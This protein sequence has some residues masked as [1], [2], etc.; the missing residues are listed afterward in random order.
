VHGPEIGVVA[1]A[2]LFTLACAQSAPEPTVP[3]QLFS[4]VTA[5]QTRCATD[6][7]C[8]VICLDDGMCCPTYCQA[9][10]VA[11]RTDAVHA[12]RA[13]HER[14]CATVDVACPSPGNCAE[15]DFHYVGI[16]SDGVCGT[17]K[18]PGVRSSLGIATPAA[19]P[20]VTRLVFTSTRSERSRDSHETTERFVLEGQQIRFTRTPTGAHASRRSSVSSTSGADDDDRRAID[21]LLAETDLL[22]TKAYEDKIRPNPGSYLSVS[23]VY[24]DDAGTR[25]WSSAGPT[26]GDRPFETT[27]AYR[28]SQTVLAGLRRI[29][30]ENDPSAFQ[31]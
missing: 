9:C 24:V 30:E 2:L 5:A 28:R 6:D 15:P 11:V 3:P 8:A 27:E 17:R 16:C 21:S 14:R 10:D 1:L 19:P 29:A 22:N 7:E 20:K 26:D 18:A 12:V 23:L 13:Q 4:D 31:R 25:T